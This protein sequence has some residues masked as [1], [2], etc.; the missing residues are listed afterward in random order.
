MCLEDDVK[1]DKIVIAVI[2]VLLPSAVVQGLTKR[3]QARSLDILKASLA[4]CF[5]TYFYFEKDGSLSLEIRE[6]G[7]L[8]MRSSINNRK[9]N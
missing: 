1:I 6:C 5:M 4:S 2:Y 3:F 8:F 7:D 9:G